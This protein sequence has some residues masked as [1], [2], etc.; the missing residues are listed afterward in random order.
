MFELNE[1]HREALLNILERCNEKIQQ[2]NYSINSHHV[3]NDDDESFIDW[4]N[5]DLFL[6]IEKKKLIEKSLIDN[7]IDF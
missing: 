6:E 2:L 5:M 3:K 7:K 1:N 4:R